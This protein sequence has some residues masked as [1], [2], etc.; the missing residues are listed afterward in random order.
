[1]IQVV[2]LVATVIVPQY[3]STRTVS[4]DWPFFRTMAECQRAAAMM[5]NVPPPVGEIMCETH[6]LNLATGRIQ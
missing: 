3:G 4:A 6:Q 5:Q 1:M 2:L